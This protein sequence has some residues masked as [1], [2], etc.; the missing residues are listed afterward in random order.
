MRDYDPTT[1]RYLQADPLGLVDGAS[2]YGYVRQN[3]GRYVDPRGEEHLTPSGHAWCDMIR[4]TGLMGGV[5]AGCNHVPQIQQCTATT[6]PDL[7]LPPPIVNSEREP[8]KP[9]PDD[10]YTPPKRWDGKKVPNPNGPGYGYPDK[11]GNVWI[12]TGIGGAAHGGPH[13]DVE[14]PGGGY[15]NIFP[16]GAER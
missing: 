5:P 15:K 4:T 1:G 9:G 12:P 13:W 8:G 10:G 16:G 2:V 14:K 7:L 6:E 3:P 11:D